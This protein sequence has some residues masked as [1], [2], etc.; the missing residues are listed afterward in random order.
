[1]KKNMLAFIFALLSLCTIQ[2]V[3]AANISPSVEQLNLDAQNPTNQ[4]FTLTL[5]ENPEEIAGQTG[6]IRVRLRYPRKL[7]S[8]TPQRSISIPFTDGVIGE[9]API[10]ISLKK[11]ERLKRARNT[12]IRLVIPKRFKRLYGISNSSIP[13]NITAENQAGSGGGNSGNNGDS[14]PVDC[15]N[16]T[17]ADFL[18]TN[19]KD[20]GD[21]SLRNIVGQASS[22]ATIGFDCSLKEKTIRLTSGQIEINKNL[23]FDG[24]NTTN[25]KGEP[26][27]TISGNKR[28]RIFDV[29]FIDGSNIAFRNLILADGFLN[30]NGKEGA[31]AAIRAEG[32]SSI[33]ISN[34]IFRNNHAQ[35]FGGGAIRTETRN[36]L[37]VSDSIF[38]NNTTDGL[39]VAG[40]IS[41]SGAGAISVDTDSDLS[42]QNSTFS[43]NK[44][45]DGGAINIHESSLTIISSEFSRNDVAE[46]GSVANFTHGFGGALFA[47]TST[48]RFSG[49]RERETG[50]VTLSKVLFDRNNAITGGGFYLIGSGADAVTI[51]KTNATNNFASGGAG[52]GALSSPFSTLDEQPTLQITDSSFVNN[53]TN[54][55]GGGLEISVATGNPL[56]IVNS[57]FS[58]NQAVDSPPRRLLARGGAINFRAVGKVCNIRNCTFAKN[59]SS[60]DGGAFW[61]AS[62]AISLMNNIFAYNQSGDGTR[63]RNHTNMTFA[64]SAGGNIQSTELSSNETLVT[65]DVILL[66]PR[67]EDLK[68]I[69]DLLVHPLKEG[70]PAIDAGIIFGAPDKDQLG[71]FRDD[72]PDIGAVEF[73]LN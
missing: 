11:P 45:T 5:D 58:Q 12:K 17:S 73:D 34:C 6:S 37:N 15:E 10:T 65:E 60:D 38:E 35:G 30:T 14:K 46:K 49:Q 16:I 41:D 71:N 72:N 20:T 31:G 22:G 64:T 43:R 28:S 61:G 66:D 13:L 44:G 67:L 3:Y 40:E 8:V 18:V 27:L 26:T 55:A 39:D 57:T 48:G 70:S 21:G 4:N 62:R 42:I 56:F 53:L 59:R 19:T 25:R 52:G 54:G 33:N 47:D 1:M 29:L 9:S 32:R 23:S 63:G 68:E 2:S 51:D 24:S 36:V 7:L 50:D 69:N